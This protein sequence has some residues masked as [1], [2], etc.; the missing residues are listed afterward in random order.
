M[1]LGVMGSGVALPG[2]NPK[3]VIDGGLIIHTP[4]AIAAQTYTPA[5]AL[6]HDSALV[7]NY[8]NTPIRVTVTA[9]TMLGSKVYLV[10]PT[11]AVA[12]GFDGADPIS[13]ITS[14]P[15]D[16]GATAGAFEVSALTAVAALTETVYVSI[17]FNEK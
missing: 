1:S 10:L 5:S 12:V 6:L 4:A 7:T 17:V 14:E 13:A 2:E 8:S 16:L 11:Q 3:K 9:A 15:V